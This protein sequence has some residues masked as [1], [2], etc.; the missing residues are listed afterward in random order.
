MEQ[1]KI[2]KYK[3][4]QDY[5]SNSI[6][7]RTISGVSL[8]RRAMLEKDIPN[9]LYPGSDAD[10]E[11]NYLTAVARGMKKIASSS[12]G[13]NWAGAGGTVRQM[14]EVYSPL[15][16]YSNLNLPRDR[17]TINAWCRAFYVLNPFVFNAISLHATYPIAK[18]NIK[19][20]N[21][22]V[23]TF[24]AEMIEELDLMNVIV[25]LAQEFWLL[26]ESIT[27]AELNESTG[28]WAQI[29]IQNPDYII[30][31]Q[32]VVNNE[33]L[34]YL[35][36]DENLKRICKGNSPS[37]IA[38][39]NQL[40]KAIVEKVRRD[41]NI[42]LSNL[43]CSHL[44]RRISP[45]ETRG[46]GLPVPAFKALMLFDTFR[47][48][49]YTQA[50]SFVNPITHVKIG[51][52]E[53][54][55]RPEDVEQVRDIFEQAEQDRNFKIFSHQDLAIERIGAGQGI[56]DISGDITQLIKEIYI[57]LMVPSVLMEGGGDTTYANGGIVLDVLR[58]RY[59]QFRTMLSIW[60][61]RKIF[62]PIAEI[63]E[64]YE[65]VDGQNKLIVPEIDWNYMSMFDMGDHISNLIQIT[66]P[67]AKRASFQTL[68]RSMGMDWE[69]EKRKMREED[70]WEAIRAKEKLSLEQ[71]PLAELRTLNENSEIPEVPTKLLEGESPYTTPVAGEETE[72]PV[73]GQQ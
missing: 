72:A 24:F 12:D 36:P 61:K 60:L 33:P 44:A 29:N 68:F 53:Y 55:P 62:A 45:Y 15:W 41:E 73:P 50:S 16:M 17:A 43:N 1:F 6:N 54:K 5:N 27:Y 9:G 11:L 25:Q 56:Y 18:L 52:A 64:F 69:E 32:S 22:K 37:D 67:D 35:R 19:C 26:G 23:E 38:Q 47:E 28:K 34:I 20:K 7:Q 30:I 51:S 40:D 65:K 4:F 3:P 14:G 66:A 49:K 8:Q 31:K 71:M 46:T 63:N 59:M 70:I 13:S 39:R 2:G 48:A 57:A 10:R 42:P 21:K 58:T